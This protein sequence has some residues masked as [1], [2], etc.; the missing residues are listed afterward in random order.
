MNESRR[1]LELLVPVRNKLFRRHAVKELQ[2]FLLAGSAC[3]FALVILARI[4][5]VP[6][7]DLYAAAILAVLAAVFLYRI[8]RGR[9]ADKDAAAVFNQFVEDDRVITAYAFLGSDEQLAVLQLK[10]AVSRMRGKQA[11]V[12]DDKQK[13]LVPKRIFPA[14]ALI[15]LAGAG[16][17]FPNEAMERA[18]QIEKK[19]EVIEE[20]KKKLSKQIDGTKNDQVKKALEA[21]K[22]KAES[23]DVREVLKE[24]EKQTAQLKLKQHKLAE[25]EK[26]TQGLE[27]DLRNAGFNDLAASLKEKDLEKLEK[28]LNNQNSSWDKLT[29]EQKEI[30]EALQEK[31]GPLNEKEIA[32]AV[33]KISEGMQ[34]GEALKQL[35]AASEQ[36]GEK[37]SEL[38]GLLGEAGV[39]PQD[40]AAAGSGQANEDSPETEG[41]SQTNGGD[42]KAGA[43]KEPGN[44]PSGSPAGGQNG[45][46]G[47]GGGN[48]SGGKGKGS[49]KGAGTGQGS[50][51]LLTV[52]S[53]IGGK[54]QI[55][56]DT[57]GKLGEGE[58]SRQEGN[59]PVL[60]GT[61]R[62]YR[63]VYG[64]YEK[65]YRE[66]TE[67]LQLP[68]E[69]NEIVKNYFSNIDPE[70]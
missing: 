51:E 24:L 56:K 21:L 54:E 48:G 8:W 27:N 43:G 3:I 19:K 7:F 40:L 57:A 30:L 36:L 10:D 16:L 59:G 49:G 26:R 42:G 6:F 15:M 12:L 33:S 18:G 28:E 63:E 52:P 13:F 20:T 50:R 35:A 58:S 4:I 39:P 64:S 9:P 60:R 47:A 11:E 70:R 41:G 69:L 32:D 22:E 55:Q 61:L 2:L 68:S 1:F 5:P 31:A 29:A 37:G 65:S 45:P 34:A 67:R 14:I 46:A 23:G 44:G 62:D 53:K 25:Q 17:Y 66:G 38:R